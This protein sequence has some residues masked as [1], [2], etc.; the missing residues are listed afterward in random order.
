MRRIPN[1]MVAGLA[2]V[3]AAACGGSGGN[4]GSGPTDGNTGGMTGSTSNSITVSNN[5]FDPAT[6]TVAP[7]TTVTWT[8]A[9]GSVGHNVTFDDGTKSST[10][11]TGTFV[12]TFG[13]AGTY[14]YHCTIHA[15][16]GMTGTVTVK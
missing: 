1:C 6:T 11:S 5:R 16:L 15:S 4:Y 3:A 14:P 12:R 9:Q 7:G 10:Q 2:I 8:W 13:T